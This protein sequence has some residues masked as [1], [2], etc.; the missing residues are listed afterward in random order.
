MIVL[1]Q[2][3]AILMT[4]KA[5]LKSQP[6][7][8]NANKPSCIDLILTNKSSTLLC[9]RNRFVWFSQDESYC[10]ED[11]LEACNKHPRLPFSF[12]NINRR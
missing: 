1:F 10:Y 12:S 11:I 9:D 2:Y 3:S 8:K 4:W 5:L 6:A 7:I